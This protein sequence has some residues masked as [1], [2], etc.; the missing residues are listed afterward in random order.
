MTIGE[1]IRLIRKETGLNQT[2]FGEK[3]GL[4]QSSL[5]QI[6]SGVR[7]ATDRTIILICE[8]Y[9]VREEWL[10]NGTGEMFL[11]TDST[12]VSQLS[13]E[14]GLDAFEK[15]LIE[16]FLKMKPEERAVIKTYV[17]NL[18]DTLTTDETAYK[19][20]RA[21]YDREHAL[22]FAARGGDTSGLAEAAERFNSTFPA[23]EN[24]DGM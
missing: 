8:K 4:R 6:E 22:P 19:E 14:Y 16:G 12:I 21:E 2:D 1:R 3:V 13:S 11:E 20:F 23:A 18:I 9:G 10:R 5:G 17:H 15:V 7:N 24:K